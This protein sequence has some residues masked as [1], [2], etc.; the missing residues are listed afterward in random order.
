M[1]VVNQYHP[2]ALWQEGTL[3][4]VFSTRFDFDHSFGLTISIGAG[5]NW[6]FKQITQDIN[7]R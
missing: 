7:T 5:I 3:L 4:D 6:I 2:F 1:M